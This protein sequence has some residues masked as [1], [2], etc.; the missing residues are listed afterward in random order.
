[1]NSMSNT[2]RHALTLEEVLPGGVV[3]RFRQGVQTEQIA[4][5]ADI[6]AED[7][8][9]VETAMTKCSTWLAGHANEVLMRAAEL[10]RKAK[11][12]ALG[13]KE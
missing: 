11:A 8:K 4:Q 9:A 3:E 13:H 5:V 2:M 6:C 12:N 10:H 7:C 1:M